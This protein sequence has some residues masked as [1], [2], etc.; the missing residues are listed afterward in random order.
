MAINYQKKFNRRKTDRRNKPVHKDF[1]YQFVTVVSIAAWCLLIAGLI[2]FHFARPEFIGGHIQMGMT[3]GGGWSPEYQQMMAML[4]QLS[5]GSSVISLILKMRRC[6]RK[7]DFIGLN[8]FFVFGI[9]V[10][11]L[12]SMP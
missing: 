7:N 10:V 5:L 4:L 12:L 1:L 11:S 2:A 8:L 6:R 9:S 3:R